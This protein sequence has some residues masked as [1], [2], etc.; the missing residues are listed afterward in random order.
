M[1][2][3]L[4]LIRAGAIAPVRRWL[5]ERGRDPAPFLAAVGIDWAPED[6]P[7]ALV[8]LRAVFELI[9]DVARAEGPEAPH[10]IAAERSAFEIGPVISDS[11]T[12]AT[13]RAGLHRVARRM[14]SHCTHEVFI[15]EDRP[16]HLHVTDGWMTNQR[17]DE[18]LHAGQQYVAGI[19]EMIC[20]AAAG[21]VARLRRVD[22][23]PH[24]DHGLSH[25]RSWLGDRVHVARDRTLQIEIS[26][27][28]ADAAV[29]PMPKSEAGPMGGSETADI[30]RIETLSEGV[31]AMV[32]SMLPY[33]APTIEHA[34]HAV[35]VGPRTLRRR[36][37]EEGK[38]FSDILD[39]TR[40]RIALNR[41]RSGDAPAIGE[42]ARQLGYSRTAAL[43]RAMK[44]WTGNAPSKIRRAGGVVG[45]DC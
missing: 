43:T 6:D 42:L 3:S 14:S 11:V 45:D 39:A 41:L 28:V 13:V 7:A 32:A 29:P 19:V 23:V 37:R 26:D 31:A 9:R 1:T 38:A 10:L 8:P 15:V 40:A 30:D 12:G 33:A 34:A 17:D 5:R 27:A 24:P 36:L 2:R 20:G 22:I 18:T 21:N 4:P 35:G 16:G 25:L 44:R